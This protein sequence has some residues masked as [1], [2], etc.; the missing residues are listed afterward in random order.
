VLSIG[1]WVT[2]GNTV[3]VNLAYQCMITA[4]KHGCN[5]F[6]NAEAYMAGKAE[7]VMGAALKRM[8]TED[9]IH[10]E[11]VLVSTKIFFGTKIPGQNT[12]GLSRK[13]I[14]EGTNA[15]LKR[16]QLDYVDLIFCHRPDS[17]TPI[18]ETVR[19]MNYII[20]SGKAFYWGT[21]EWSA[22][23][24]KTAYQIA[25]KLNLIP[26]LMEQPQYNVLHRTRFEKEYAELY[27]KYEFGTT[28]WSPLASGIL[29]GKYSSSDP[30]T[31]PKDSRLN[32]VQYKWLQ[33]AFVS[34]KGLN[35]L[36]EKDVDSILSK[37]KKLK[38]EVADKLG[39]TVSQLCIAWCVKNKNVSTVI[40]GA[41][42]VEQVKEN[43][44]SLKVV[45]K[46]TDEV[47]QQIEAILKNKPH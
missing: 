2:Q 29:T 38:E 35:G 7:E 21:S 4:Y 28:I 39:C 17:N 5:F 33:D 41:S 44:E 30:S 40:T 18:E 43:F 37:V 14:I 47:M 3:D 36:E 12:T 42:K 31:F 24:I 20:D 23:E 15:S 46:L 8:F 11:S 34:G 19:A 16:L 13:H 1:A 45:P 22:A 6:D 32:D 27:E 25:E 9:K 26:P 10:R